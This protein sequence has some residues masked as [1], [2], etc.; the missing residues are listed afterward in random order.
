MTVYKQRLDALVNV[1][2]TSIS[3]PVCTCNVLKEDNGS[4]GVDGTT[5]TYSVIPFQLNLR[6]I[7]N[8][9]VNKAN[10]GTLIMV[11]KRH[12]KVATL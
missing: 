7:L 1:G 11:S 5:E 4:Y 3:S 12:K 2:I 6:I 8:L 9:Q 10:T